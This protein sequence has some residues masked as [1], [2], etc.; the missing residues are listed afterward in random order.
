MVAASHGAVALD[1]AAIPA[2]ETPATEQNRGI[3]IGWLNQMLMDQRQADTFVFE[4]SS[5]NAATVLPN[6]ALDVARLDMPAFTS[7]QELFAAV[8][9]NAVIITDYR[10]TISQ[11]TS[12][13][14]HQYLA[15]FHLV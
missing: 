5:G 15:D 13:D 8:H 9:S 6:L 11:H 10:D 2:A 3:E 12:A 1:G 4:A 7:V 14:L